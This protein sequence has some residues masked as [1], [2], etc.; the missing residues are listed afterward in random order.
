MRWDHRI[1]PAPDRLYAAGCSPEAIAMRERFVRS[2][3]AAW[4]RAGDRDTADRL[5]SAADA[6]AT[7]FQETG[8][9]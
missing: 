1:P 9:R 4:A 3:A 5:S 7:R 2:A 6:L 8:A